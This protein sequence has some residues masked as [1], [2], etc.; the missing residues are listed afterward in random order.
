TQEIL[1]RPAFN[2]L[3]GTYK[4]FVELEYH[5]KECYK[6]VTNQLDWNNPKGHE[7]PFDLSKP[8]P[9]IE[10]QG[11]QVVPADY[12]FNNDLE[13]L[14]GGSSSKKYT[15]STTKTKDAKYDN[16]EGIED[17]VSTL[18][19]PV[20][21][22][23]DKFSMWGIS[24]WGP[25]RQ[26]L[27]GYASN[28]ESK[29]DVISR[30][31]M[32][33]VTRVKVMM[34]Y[35]YGYLEEIMIRR[36]DQTLHKFKEDDFPRVNLRDIEDLMLLLLQ[37]NLQ[38]RARCHLRPECS[39]EDVHHTCCPNKPPTPDRAWN[40]GNSANSRPPQK[41]ISNT[42]KARKPPRTPAFNLL[43]GTYKSFM[44]LEYHFKE[45]YKAIT[46]QLDWN[47]PKGHEYPFNLS[48]PLPLI[49][50]QGRQVV[51]ADYFFNNDL[52]Y[53]KGGSLSKKYTTSTTKT[54]AAK[55]DNIEGIEDKFYGYASNKESKHDVISRKRII[56][57]THVKVMKWYGYGYLEE[58]MIRRE[59][60]TLHKFKEDDF[61]RVNLR[62]IEDLLLLLVQKK[63]SNLEQ[64]V[65]FDLNVALRK[66]TIRVVIFK[67][68]EDLQLGV[69]SYQ[70]KFN[71]T[72]LD[73]FRSHI[74]KITPYTAYKNPQ[75]ITY[76]EKYKR[77]KLMRSDE[78]YKF[79]DGTL[80]SI[81]NVLHDIA[82]NLR[83]E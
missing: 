71:L 50:A 62:D 17:K 22:T 78:I 58:V 53:L 83:M 67:R 35:G 55:Y 26:K 48:K 47:N 25:K 29:H 80:T 52:E 63:L 40:D 66:F 19:S 69:K 27:Y 6:A 4:S 11:R 31:R 28:K 33:A 65:I 39:T 16:I 79:C 38:L 23:Y 32:I 72:K 13:Y 10:A 1:V 57:V 42:A 54:K 44:E 37:K 51:P 41:W 45:C 70:K 9:L 24:H 21:V 60:Q 68:V 82:N 59:D 14:K 12:F 7:Y 64:D 8:L 15:T 75:G 2:L 49:E 61:P 73:T 76:L 77:N 43:K 34:W 56:T 18:W 3:K 81:R 46:N 20:K 30:K 74:S 36:E 5:F